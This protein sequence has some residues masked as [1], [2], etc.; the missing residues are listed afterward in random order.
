MAAQW[1][2]CAIP[3]VCHSVATSGKLVGPQ[4]AHLKRFI[5]VESKKIVTGIYLSA[6][7]KTP[8][9]FTVSYVFF[10]SS[11]VHFFRMEIS[12]HFNLKLWQL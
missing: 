12:N 6:K 1:G 11:L 8:V 10:I 2:R 3:L 7:L 5:R 4:V 9:V